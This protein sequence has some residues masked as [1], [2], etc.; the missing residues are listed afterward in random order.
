MHKPYGKLILAR[1][2]QSEWN[3]LGKWTGTRDRHLTEYGFSKS[4]EMGSLI[5]DIHVDQAFA[6][7]QVRSIETLTCMLN[8]CKR[9][10][11]P[12]EHS[13]ALNERDYGD[14]TGKNKWEMKQLLGDDV[15]K[16]LRRGWDFPIPNGESL[17]D[18]YDRAVPYYTNTIVPSVLS[19]KNTLVV[20]HGNSLRSLLKYIEQVSDEEIADIE[21]PFGSVIIY[22][23][24]EQG[25]MKS[26]ETRS[27]TPD[28]TS[29]LPQV[30][31]TIGP[32]SE[33]EAIVASMIKSGVD[34]IR[35]NFSW[36]TPEDHLRH[37]R[38]VRKLAKEDNRYIPIIADLPGPR[39]QHSDVHTFDT[40]EAI[41]TEH[42]RNLL[43]LILQEGVEYVALSFIKD[44]QDI[45]AYKAV[46]GTDIKVVAKIERRE[47][48]EAVDGIIEN[49]DAVM[50]ARGDLGSAVPLEKIPFIQKD[51]IERCNAMGK[52]VIVATQM[53]L[54]MTEHSEPT[55]AEVSDVADAITEGADAVMLSEETAK[56]KYP[57]E[58]SAMMERIVT[59]A[60]SHS[61]KKTPLHLL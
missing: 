50:I 46:L 21:F 7:M 40:Q 5:N 48:V 42:E 17:A 35:L 8:I 4:E 36:G 19:G 14:Y 9:Y 37:I 1:H 59:E 33:S 28:V 44:A 25:H 57:I 11:V 12:T 24:D 29:M 16:Q 30:V 27:V 3:K 47:A 52:P 13:G 6:S 39:V 58:S 23:I 43:P 53:M 15:F 18:V 60:R 20:A 32:S 2:H 34:V 26:K 56:G 41:P 54:S 45:M 31:A 38:L 51:I 55:R 61:T 10:E 22:D 49:A